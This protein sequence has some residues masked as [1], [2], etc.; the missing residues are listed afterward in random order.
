M[1]R[2]IKVSLYPNKEQKELLDKTFGCSRF[3]YNKMLEERI[4]IYEELKED[5]QALYDYKYKT[6]KQ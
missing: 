4:K 3:L 5:K 2:S 6:E 1:Y